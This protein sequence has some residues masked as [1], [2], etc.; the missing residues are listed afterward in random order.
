MPFSDRDYKGYIVK[1]F[2]F[3]K[4]SIIKIN[5][6]VLF[7]FLS[8]MF[9]VVASCNGL[10]ANEASSSA[11]YPE[12]KLGWKLGAQAY[13]FNL[14]T[15]FEAIDK[16][17]SCGLKYVEAYPEQVIGGGIEG[18]MD[19]HMDAFTRSKILQKLKDKGIKLI[20][21][22]VVN[23]GTD[24]EWRRIFEFGKAMNIETITSEPLE[25]DI[26]L[27]S[28]LCD[29][30]QINVAMHNHPQPRSYWNPDMLLAAIKGQSSRIGAC[31][32]IGHWVRSGLDPV[33]CLKKL[34]GHVL[35]LHMKDLN[36]KNG[37]EDRDVHWGTGVANTDGVIK[38]LK[39]QHFKGMISAEYERNWENNVPDVT[40]SVAYFRNALK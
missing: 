9:T 28:K 4:M 32:D 15:F 1:S 17:D 40:A 29:E 31:A 22:G 25:K 16:I 10:T 37:E 11:A 18:K 2:K 24:E 35:Q 8:G 13:T 3:L 21:Y 38:E 5:A 19:Y 34:E 33:E 14:F 36:D 26:P 27:L 7:A 30:Y 20:A 39:R 12:T 6:F 23:A